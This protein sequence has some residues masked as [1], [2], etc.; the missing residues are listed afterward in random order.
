M[1]I[2]RS[3]I[4]RSLALAF[5]I[6]ALSGCAQSQ[7]SFGEISDLIRPSATAVSE[8]AAEASPTAAFDDQG[9][10]RAAGQRERSFMYE[11]VKVE[12]SDGA[13]AE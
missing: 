7:D 11:G 10:A 9:I 8:P 4:S 12:M 5:A 1:Y 13:L 3:V 2:T 6:F